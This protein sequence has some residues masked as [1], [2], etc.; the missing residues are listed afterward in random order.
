MS[1][2]KNGLA[3][4]VAHLFHRESFDRGTRGSTYESWSFNIAVWSMDYAHPRQAITFF[5]VKF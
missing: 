4:K 2:R 1:I 5:Y 3:A